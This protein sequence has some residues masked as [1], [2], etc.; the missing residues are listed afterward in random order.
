M[1]SEAIGLG[2]AGKNKLAKQI[3]P[4]LEGTVAGKTKLTLARFFSSCCSANRR[5]SDYSCASNFF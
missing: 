4:A 3:A 1:E 5:N 2:R